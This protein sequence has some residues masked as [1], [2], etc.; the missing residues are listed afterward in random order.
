MGT[1]QATRWLLIPL[2]IAVP[3][4]PDILRTGLAVAVVCGM[5]GITVCAPI[6]DAGL[7]LAD[8]SLLLA[9]RTVDLMNT[10][11]VTSAGTTS[12][13]PVAVVMG[14]A[15]LPAAVALGDMDLLL[16]DPHGAPL[17]ED[18][19]RPG[20]QFRCVFTIGVF[21]GEGDVGVRPAHYAVGSGGPVRFLG[22]MKPLVEGV[23]FHLAVEVLRGPIGLNFLVLMYGLVL[24]RGIPTKG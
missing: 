14:G 23:D 24:L 4:N 11:E 9:D 20:E 2:D 17:V 15:Q 10:L 18:V 22:D 6:V 13:F 3:L 8:P 5:V 7:T 19:H 12:T 21:K 1:A 16:P